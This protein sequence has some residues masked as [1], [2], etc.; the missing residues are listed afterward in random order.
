MFETFP[1]QNVPKKGDYL[2]FLLLYF[3]LEYDIR[4]VQDNQVGLKLNDLWSPMLMI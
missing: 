3:A 4:K 2:W 1:S